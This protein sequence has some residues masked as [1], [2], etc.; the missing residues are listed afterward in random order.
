MIQGGLVTYKVARDNQKTSSI[1]VVLLPPN[2]LFCRI[3]H[4]MIDRKIIV[5]T[6]N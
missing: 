6:I 3:R 5:K 1:N 2:I 4:A